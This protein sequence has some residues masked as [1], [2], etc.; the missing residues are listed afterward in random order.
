MR[1]ARFYLDNLRSKSLTYR[2]E[3]HAFEQRSGDSLI[4]KRYWISLLL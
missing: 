4:S 1:H 3:N 2:T